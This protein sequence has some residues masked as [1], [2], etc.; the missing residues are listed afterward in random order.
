MLL[1]AIF[2]NEK[3]NFAIILA[4]PLIVSG[5]ILVIPIEEKTYLLNR[6]SIFSLVAPVLTAFFWSIS[7]ITFKFVLINGFNPI[8]AAFINRVI[9]LPFLFFIAASTKELN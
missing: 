5:I 1:A 8:F 2:L 7:L 6:F 4:T 9:S 3:L